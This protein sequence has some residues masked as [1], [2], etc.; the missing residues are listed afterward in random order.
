MALSDSI[1]FDADVAFCVADMGGTLQWN[2]DSTPYGVSYACVIGTVSEGTHIEDMAG[3]MA[4]INFILV[5][6]TSLLVNGRPDAN[7]KIKINGGT[8]AYRVVRVETDEADAALNLFVEE[9]TA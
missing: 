8:N 5:I 3:Y 9:I 6:Q 7:D 1:D 2:G 4:E